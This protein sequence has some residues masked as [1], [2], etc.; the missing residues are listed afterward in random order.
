MRVGMFGVR[1]GMMGCVWECWGA[2]ENVGVHVGMFGVRVGM[3]GCVW[4]C[5]GCVWE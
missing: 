1:V 2:Y 5:L 3:L 4:E